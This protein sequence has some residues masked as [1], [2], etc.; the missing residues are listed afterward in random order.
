MHMAPGLYPTLLY[1]HQAEASRFQLPHLRTGVILNDSSNIRKT[2]KVEHSKHG[3]I[4]GSLAN[5]I[6]N[7]SRV[8]T[9]GLSAERSPLVGTFTEDDILEMVLVSHLKLYQ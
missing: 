6:D 2:R 1:Q 5:R 4:N 3:Q 8:N 9:W 7:S